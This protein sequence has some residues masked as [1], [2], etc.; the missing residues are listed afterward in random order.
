MKLNH[1]TKKTILLLTI[2]LLCGFS[3]KAFGENTTSEILSLKS[4]NNDLL[5]G[6]AKRYPK[7]KFSK[8]TNPD[9]VLIELS[10]TKLHDK[11]KFNDSAQKDFL[12]NLEFITDLT[13]GTAKY[14]NNKTKV[15]IVL[16]LNE[17]FKPFPSIVSTKDNTIRISF[18]EPLK[19]QPTQEIKPQEEQAEQELQVLKDLYNKAVEENTIGDVEK[20][21][22]LYKE[23]I[24]RNNNFFLARY[25][26]AKIYSDKGNYDQSQKLLLS[27]IT[28]IENKK[29]E[30]I[31]KRPL[32]LSK[33][34][35]GLIYLI[36]DEFNKAQEQFN[37]IIIIDPFFY[38]A[39]YNLG[40]TYEKVQD[41]EQA[42]LNFKKVVELKPD[43]ALA[44]YHLGI[45]NLILKNKEDA[46][47]NL[48]K[49]LSVAPESS[50]G[51]LSEKE[52]QKLGRRKKNKLPG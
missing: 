24:S 29:D 48:E 44:Y 11:F 42:I 46:I 34:L 41:A 10:E 8:F 15:S 31:D 20:S 49:V 27:L 23:L 2:I 32:V 40:L 47:S 18:N 37:E 39:Y 21:E 13:I 36:K 26:L 51:K 14:K 4:E 9:K 1:T 30:I 28:D 25:N 52:L 3:T 17:A 7:V 38:E 35:L 22:E 45:L 50:I 19:V 12:N 43:Y 33:N 5:I 6:V 16:T